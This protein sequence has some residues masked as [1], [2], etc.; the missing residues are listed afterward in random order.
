MMKELL[1]PIAVPVMIFLL[2]AAGCREPE[3]PGTNPVVP[4]NP[5]E[6]TVELTESELLSAF[7]LTKGSITASA[8][9]KKIANDTPSA[10]SV[11]FTER[12]FIAYDDEA[13][14]FTVKVKGTKNG[15]NFSNTITME[16]FTHPY[17]SVPF[18]KNFGDKLKFDAALE[19]NL[20][21]QNFIDLLKNAANI[22]DHLELKFTLKNGKIIDIANS[23]EPYKFTADFAENSGKIKLTP[24][25]ELIYKKLAEG[26]SEKTEK[27]PVTTVG[28]VF[29]NIE[30]NYFTENDV[31]DYVAEK[32]KDEIIKVPANTF[33][34]Y[35]YARA[36]YLNATPSDI[37]NVGEGSKFKK[38]QDTYKK[39]DGQ[40][41]IIDA[42]GDSDLSY[43]LDKPKDRGIKA[44]DYSGTISVNYYIQRN[45][46]IAD[47]KDGTYNGSYVIKPVHVE[48]TGFLKVSEN[49]LKQNFLFSL[50]KTG[51][52]GV[53]KPKWLNRNID[54]IE[55]LGAQTPEGFA[56]KNPHLIDY[57]NH[58]TDD[59]YLSVNG[60]TEL[61]D[62][63]VASKQYVS[64]AKGQAPKEYSLL[65][66]SIRMN[67]V[68]NEKDLVLI[69][70]FEGSG[71]PIKLTLSPFP[72]N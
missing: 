30:Y 10:S 18:S 69:F 16:G 37:F 27:V 15:K 8:A 70:T 9:A 3:N 19:D 13:G 20:K 22:A 35:I 45:K 48:K 25:Y 46:F 21:L 42:H 1:K 44:D 47:I 23:A 71:S 62:L 7:S 53:A 58:N 34:S 49:F 5:N 36:K 29:R 56:L 4:Q 39:S 63:A 72:W 33:A 55:L 26:A 61:T 43:A 24:K 40:I 32:V 60:L 68:K 31:F 66:T 2:F 28:S 51:N 12:N 41:Q 65:I 6:L 64:I 38:Y 54:N 57:A 14:T 52:T 17:N 59:Y 50:I 67:K 11:I